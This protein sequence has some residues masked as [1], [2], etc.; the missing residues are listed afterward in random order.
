MPLDDATA[1]AVVTGGGTGIGLATAEALG[2]AGFAIV[3]SGRRSHV[4]E[5][6]AA[7]IRRRTGA[8]VE[9][10]RGD[11]GNTLE[12]VSLISHTIEWFGRVDVLVNNAAPYEP[13]PLLDMTEAA[14]NSTVNAA[15]RGVAFC[16]TA[17]ATAMRSQGAGRIVSVASV[18]AFA[19]EPEVAHYNA[20]KAG[21]VSL[22]RSMAIEF[23]RFGISVNAVAP[24]WIRTPASEQNLA[25]AT[26]EALLRVNPL[27]RCGEPHEVANVIRYL[28]TDAPAFLT[29]TTILVD[30]GQSAA[31]AMP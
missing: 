30:G 13:V 21:V 28:A 4:L 22:T 7:E 27:G 14:W 17:A 10:C 19:S 9:T 3:I 8:R 11:I 25:A 5:A 6:A 2:H 16:S 24:G 29:G 31:A 23:S 12:A 15:L 18:V 26:R 1:V 20:A